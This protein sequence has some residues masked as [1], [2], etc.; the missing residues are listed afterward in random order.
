MTALLMAMAMMSWIPADSTAYC[1][2]G[3][4]ADGTQTRARSVAQNTLPL[5]SM[6]KTNKPGPG[7]IYI[8]YVRDR[9]GSGSELD[10]WTPS[11][12]DA[13]RWNK[14]IKFRVLRRGK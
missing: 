8:W 14:P 12:S 3:R 1:L 11:C 6:I 5:G 10:F 4:M 7:G 9:I 2:R 13:L